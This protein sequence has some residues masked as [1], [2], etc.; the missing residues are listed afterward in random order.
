MPI[1]FFS[2]YTSYIFLTFPMTIPPYSFD[3]AN[4]T[5]SPS[6]TWHLVIGL[7]ALFIWWSLEFHALRLSDH[8]EL[9]FDCRQFTY[10]HGAWDCIHFLGCRVI[11]L[12][13]I[14]R[15][16]DVTS[17][18]VSAWCF[19]LPIPLGSGES[20]KYLCTLGSEVLGSRS[21]GLHVE[22]EL[23][24]PGTPRLVCRTGDCQKK[25]SLFVFLGSFRTFAM[26]TADPEFSLLRVFSLLVTDDPASCG[27][28]C[29]GWENVSYNDQ[30]WKWL[31]TCREDTGRTIWGLTLL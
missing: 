17:Q 30:R 1:F 5:R 6:S 13:N 27:R 28:F 18:S 10:I 23:F 3:N 9:L 4:V 24:R 2:S 15:V 19:H 26:I 8:W 16:I 11:V 31:G 21:H 29:K 20:Y 7:C 25:D 14:E 22:N 12:I